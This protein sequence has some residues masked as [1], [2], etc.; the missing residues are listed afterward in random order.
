MTQ[1]A[2]NE[3]GTQDPHPLWVERDAS[4]RRAVLTKILAQGPGNTDVA[5][6]CLV[7]MC[8][9]AR[10]H[11]VLNLESMRAV[12]AH[13]FAAASASCGTTTS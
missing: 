9:R 10:L 2:A 6:E 7:P 11:D 13:A 8:H 4:G 5:S 3:P 1:R 12:P